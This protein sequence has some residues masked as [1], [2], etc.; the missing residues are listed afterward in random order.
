MRDRDVVLRALSELMPIYDSGA[1]LKRAQE[2]QPKVYDAQF[3]VV[4]EPVEQPNP[5]VIE[6]EV[7]L[8]K[9]FSAEAK[10]TFFC[11][12]LIGFSVGYLVHYLIVVFQ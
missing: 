10:L 9:G 12:Y 6:R 1:A 8:K 2:A 3:E 11:G 5:V 4:N 7:I